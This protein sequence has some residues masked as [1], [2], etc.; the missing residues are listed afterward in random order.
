MKKII[1]V[2]L[3][4]LVASEALACPGCTY[5]RVMPT[6][7]VFAALRLMA[8]CAIAFTVLDLVRTVEGFIV[9][10]V[11]Y[12]FAWRMAVWYSH[13]A[14]AEGFVEWLALGFLLVLSA[15]VPAVMVIKWI[16][17]FKWFRLKPGEGVSWRRA[18]LIIPV[19]F[20]IA[21]V[22]GIVTRY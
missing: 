14:V 15:G 18:L 13:P 10:E 21:V 1:P 19:F 8:V 20:L 11:L 2:C 17:R 4:L 12:F 3:L 22:E 6:W 7:P 16:G 9:Y 5:E